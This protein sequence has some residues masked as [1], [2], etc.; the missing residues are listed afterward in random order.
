[1]KSSSVIPETFSVIIVEF[2]PYYAGIES[3]GFAGRFMKTIPHITGNAD[4]G[5]IGFTALN[6]ILRPDKS[7]R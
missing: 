6:N 5:M 3:H 4:T 2:Q 1:M 7:G